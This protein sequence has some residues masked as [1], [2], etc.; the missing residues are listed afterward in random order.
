MW[1]WFGQEPGHC[2]QRRISSAACPFALQLHPFT[3]NESLSWFFFGLNFSCFYF[4]LFFLNVHNIQTFILFFSKILYFII[5]FPFMFISW[6]LIT[7]QYCSG[8]CHTL[9]WISHVF[10]CVPHPDPPS[11]L[12]FLVFKKYFYL[13]SLYS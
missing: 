2:L 1:N 13:L 9:T 12:P 3:L 7:L 4:I 11:C 5:F 8:F 10:T 6:R